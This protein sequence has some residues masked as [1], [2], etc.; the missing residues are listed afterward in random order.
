MAQLSDDC[1]ASS[2]PMMSVD[3][4]VRLIATRVTAIADIETVAL[5]EA[6]G[7]I[8]ANEILAPLP[9]PPFTNSAVDGYAVAS[10]DLPKDSE[11]A[12]PISGRVQAGAA[13]NAPIEP[14][15]AVRIFTGAP[16]PDGADTV[17]MQEDVRIEGDKVVLPAGLQP[18]ANVRPAG[19]DIPLGHAAL[20]IGRR[21]RPQDVALAAAFGL[22]RLD[23]I[24]RIRVAVFSTG[25][26]LVSPGERRA[27]PQLF[28]SNRFMLMA[29]LRR[30]GCEVSDLGILRDEPASLARALKDV[31]GHHDL[32]L[33]TGGVSTG[34]EDH[35]KAGVESVGRLVLWRMAIKP[36][37]PVAMGIIGGTPFIG[38][39]G[40][41]VASFV[42]FVHVVRPTILAL[43]G[44]APEPLV[45]M[46]V[47]AGFTYKKKIGRRE[48]VRVNLR[49][50][51]DGALEAIKFPREGAGL[52]S[53]LVDTD[54]LVELGEH[55][56]RVEPGQ[57]VGFLSY[58][59]LI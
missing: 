30:L 6:D 35:V 47:R 22:T 46:P 14:G 54:G 1:F 50:A 48:Y 18:G 2:G 45:P 39:P 10:R 13:A 40:N 24:R 41:P 25:D 53:S 52:L 17:F 57:T 11:Q 37:R 21:L 49:T 8:L 59:S 33:T 34:E 19:E 4:A 20:Q 12:F 27:P 5:A 42:T 9:L 58:A 16:M 44:G 29:M 32:I 36:G 23:V 51:P 31:A 3:E 15:H 28:D 55:I 43:S 26:E 7:R 38:L 56:T